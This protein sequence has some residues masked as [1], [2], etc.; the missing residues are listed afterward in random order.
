[1]NSSCVIL[2]VNKNKILLQLRDEHAPTNPNVWAF[3]GGGMDAEETPREAIIREAQEEL[4]YQLSKPVLF[5]K[6]QQAHPHFKTEYIFYETYNNQP[7]TLHE[8]ADMGW[9]SREELSDLA[10]N[11]QHR[12]ILELF[13]EFLSLR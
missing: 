5:M 11:Q 4:S 9:F 3:F 7:L 8:G 1:M 12:Y 6:R 13:F 2:L 10:M